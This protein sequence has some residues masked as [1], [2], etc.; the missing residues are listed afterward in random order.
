MSHEA[1][2]KLSEGFHLKSRLSLGG[3]P[4]P[5]SLMWLRLGLSLSPCELL[6]DCW[7]PPGQ[8]IRKAVIIRGGSHSRI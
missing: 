7:L 3:N 1:A 8:A 6:H 2:V 5:S 4:R